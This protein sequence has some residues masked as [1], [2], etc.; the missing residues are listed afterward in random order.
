MVKHNFGQ[1][2]SNK[3]VFYF[4]LLSTLPEILFGGLYPRTDLQPKEGKNGV[5]QTRRNEAKIVCI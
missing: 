5:N 2:S 4:Y 1:L 3:I